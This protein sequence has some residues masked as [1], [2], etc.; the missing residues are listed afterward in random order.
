MSSKQILQNYNLLK[1]YL[2]SLQDELRISNTS[3]F[4]ELVEHTLTS[5]FII[6]TIK[7]DEIALTEIKTELINELL[8]S[9]DWFYSLN[10]NFKELSIDSLYDDYGFEIEVNEEEVIQE[11]PESIHLNSFKD[12]L[13]E[14]DSVYLE[15]IISNNSDLILSG[16]KDAKLFILFFLSSINIFW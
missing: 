9:K 10:Y 7:A 5:D 8:N 12:N 14:E 6:S 15:K 4:H 1:E 16:F 11:K 13:D 2:L 3:F